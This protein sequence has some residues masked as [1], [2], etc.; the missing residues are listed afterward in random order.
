MKV[1]TTTITAT[2][3]DGSDISASC[4]VTV[5]P[6]KT[7]AM[8]FDK[9]EVSVV[10]TEDA[11]LYLTFNSSEVDNKSIV[12]TSSDESVATVSQNMNATYPLEV[13]VFTHKVGQAVIT[14]TAQD[15]SGVTATCTVN[16]TPLK[17]ADIK[18]TSSASVMRTVPTQ[19]TVKV[20]PAEADNQTLK[21]SSLTPEIATVD[22]SGVVTGLKTGTATIKAEATDGSG[23]SSTFQITVTP[24]LVDKVSLPS[25]MSLVKTSTQK[26][27]ATVAPEEADNQKL[28]WESGDVSIAIVDDQG[29]L[30]GVKVGTATITATATD[31]SNMSASCVVTV[32]PLQ[33]ESINHYCPV[34]VD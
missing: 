21:W 32:I 14:A 20:S 4:I 11:H 9:K 16:V 28:T 31:G 7:S 10:K 12:W 13:Y 29:N 3:T 8:M 18:L 5:T 6:L 22:E 1:G 17:V 27:T 24:R 19:L 25:S 30:T 15:G 34:K 23:V 33:T 26:L 2:A